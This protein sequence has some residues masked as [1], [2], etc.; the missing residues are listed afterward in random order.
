MCVQRR[1]TLLDGALDFN[2]CHRFIQIREHLGRLGS[3]E[4]DEIALYSSENRKV[5]KLLQQLKSLESVTKALQSDEITIN[6]TR[7][8]F[9]AVIEDFLIVP[10][11]FKL[12]QELCNERSFRVKYS[13]YRDLIVTLY[14]EKN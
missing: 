6:D 14:L 8:L 13:I 5:D 2:M 1:R 7:A 9:D 11:A 3:D 4:A 10:T 12:M